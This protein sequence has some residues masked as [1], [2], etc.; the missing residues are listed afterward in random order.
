MSMQICGLILFWFF[1]ALCFGYCF[2]YIF[3]GLEIVSALIRFLLN[4]QI[5]CEVLEMNHEMNCP[6]GSK[7]RNK[8]GVRV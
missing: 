7:I 2:V 5:I 4:Q 3:A 8:P 6:C 1:V